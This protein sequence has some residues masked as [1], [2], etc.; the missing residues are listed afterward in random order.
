[1]K[2]E[3]KSATILKPVF[4][5]E[6]VL[7]FASKDPGQTPEPSTDDSP[8]S[9]TSKPHAT[10]KGSQPRLETDTRQISLTMSKELY[11]RISKEAARKHRTIEEHLVRHLNKRYEK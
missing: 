11:D 1:M 10:K 7:Q 3:R 2:K 5:E 8:K 4:D 6:A 9:T